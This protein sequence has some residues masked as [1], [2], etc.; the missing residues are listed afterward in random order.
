[1]KRNKKTFLLSKQEREENN[2]WKKYEK[3]WFRSTRKFHY[4]VAK[5]IVKTASIH[6]KLRKYKIWSLTINI[7]K[8]ISSNLPACLLLWC[9]SLL[10][11]IIYIVRRIIYAPVD[12]DCIFFLQ[13]FIIAVIKFI[14]AAY[15][16]MKERSGLEVINMNSHADA[17]NF[18]WFK[19]L[20]NLY[21]S[22]CSQ[23]DFN[24]C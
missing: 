11:M 17:L 15:I 14:A 18:V 19:N 21:S 3:L 20:E 9:I 13:L 22:S 24:W 2:G 10:M 5:K 8:F 6:L 7:R 4:V 16:H 23:W 12:F 1:M